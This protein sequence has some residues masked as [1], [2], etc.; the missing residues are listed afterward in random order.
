MNSMSPTSRKFEKCTFYLNPIAFGRSISKERTFAEEKKKQEEHL[1]MCR[2]VWTASTNILRDPFL[3]SSKDVREA[4]RTTYQNPQTRECLRTKICRGN[5]IKTSALTYA[6]DK[7]LEKS[8]KKDEKSSKIPPLETKSK[9]HVKKPFV[10]KSYMLKSFATVPFETNHIPRSKKITNTSDL[11]RNKSS[12][13]IDSNSLR[14]RIRDQPHNIKSISSFVKTPLVTITNKS[15]KKQIESKLESKSVQDEKCKDSDVNTRGSI[16]CHTGLERSSS[17]IMVERNERIKSENLF[18]KKVVANTTREKVIDEKNIGRNVCYKNVIPRSI[19]YDKIRSTGVYLMQKRP[20]TRSKFKELDILHSRQAH[21]LSPYHQVSEEKYFNSMDNSKYQSSGIDK[22]VEQCEFKLDCHYQER[23]KSEPR[24]IRYVQNMKTKHNVTNFANKKKEQSFSPTREFRSPSRRRIQSF[25]NRKPT[26]F[27]SLTHCGLAHLTRRYSLSDD[28][29]RLDMYL[30]EIGQP[31]KFKDLNRFY[32]KVERVGVLE[33]TTSN[34]DLHPIR[35]ENELID[36][37]VWKKVK[38]YKSA[39]KELHSLVDKLKREE[40]E[41]DFLFRSKYPE[42]IKWRHEN[43]SGLRMKEKSVE[44]LKNVF[45]KKS[46]PN[47]LDNTGQKSKRQY[48]CSWSSDSVIDLS[49]KM[50]YKYNSYENSAN[51]SIKGCFGISRNLISTLSKDQIIKIKKQLNEIYS[52]NTTRILKS[53]KP[54]EIIINGN[55][56]RKIRPISLL[57]RCNSL[58]DEKELL[59]SVLQG[60]ENHFKTSNKSGPR[61]AFETSFPV[62][63]E[64]RKLLQKQLRNEMQNKLK[65]RSTKL[66]RPHSTIDIAENNKSPSNDSK[67]ILI[68][69]KKGKLKENKSQFRTIMT[70]NIEDKVK[71][72]KNNEISKKSFKKHAMDFSKIEIANESSEKIKQKIKYFEEK[73]VEELPKTIYLPRDDSSL[74]D[75]EVIRGIEDKVKA[76]QGIHLPQNHLYV[77]GLSRSVSDLK[78]FFGEKESVRRFIEYRSSSSMNIR[79]QSKNME[80]AASTEN[81]FRSRSI[82]PISDSI[83]SIL[84]NRH[85]DNSKLTHESL[86]QKLTCSSRYPILSAPPRRFSSDPTLHETVK[87]QSKIALKSSEISDVSYYKHKF[88]MKNSTS[89][90]DRTQIKYATT[91]T[92]RDILKKEHRLMPHIDIIS[93]TI[94]LKDA[95]SRSSTLEPSKKTV[96]S[97]GEV[98]R[99]RHKFEMRKSDSFVSLIGQMYTSSPDISELRDISNYLSSTWIA[100]KYSKRGD[101]ARSATEPDKTPTNQEIKRKQVYRLGST[102]PQPS[103]TM[104][105]I[106]GPL[107]NIFADKYDATKHRPTHRY[108]PVDTRLEAKYLL[109]QLKQNIDKKFKESIHNKE[110]E[111]VPPQ[112]PP[113]SV[114]GA[115][116]I[117]TEHPNQKLGELLRRESLNK[118]MKI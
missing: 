77:K 98:D 84:K 109:H 42:D 96:V 60:Q 97:S 53:E 51:S 9:K 32:S 65:E 50:F 57:V 11:D 41:K 80:D 29:S 45:I 15:C 8:I 110:F 12:Y 117:N 24:S 27:S 62:E 93:K 22:D 55:E 39:E 114:I 108:V 88:E 6:K 70:D 71:Y 1:P 68:D 19:N 23:S 95:I 99:I 7:L 49:S 92:H 112:P 115:I 100:H 3:Q 13:S 43:D 48:G 30:H 47:E 67:N 21:S 89:S 107:Y 4:V 113:P 76:N 31:E 72:S 59:G 63:D 82:S 5:I 91:S 103:K 78:E 54:V 2:R 106:L 17:F 37:N 118:R 18:S 116:N 10:T 87:S 36:F 101:N 90:K 20:V 58:A 69:Q 83:H 14:K 35:K 25:R 94:A 102:S 28:E 34:I 105:D 73:R 86:T 38:N 66:L 52:N 111:I 61:S 79:M 56:I 85:N 26:D 44:D 81:Y 74:E 16:P 104:N 46:V 75:I 40:R 33:R 64:K